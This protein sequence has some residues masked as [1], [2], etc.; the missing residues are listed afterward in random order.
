MLSVSTTLSYAQGTLKKG[1][2][3][4]V[5]NACLYPTSFTN[6]VIPGDTSFVAS[7]VTVVSDK[8]R[9]GFVTG[10]TR[11]STSPSQEAGQPFL[12][13]IYT[14]GESTYRMVFNDKVSSF[15]Q[16]ET[17]K[18]LLDSLGYEAF[19]ANTKEMDRLYDRD[20]KEDQIVNLLSKKYNTP[21]IVVLRDNKIDQRVDSN[22]EGSGR[23]KNATGVMAMS[24]YNKWEL[25]NRLNNE[26]K[27]VDEVAVKEEVNVEWN[28]VEKS[29]QSELPVPSD[30]ML[31]VNAK[32][33]KS[34]VN[35]LVGN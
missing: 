25:Y 18:M 27:K 28:K 10:I 13:Y 17:V 9:E 1:A 23:S 31:F 30:V 2:R 22:C 32:A 15:I 4:C 8:G 5:I 19:T 29:N 12:D 20:Y 33:A 21:T 3:I 6:M 26:I 14:S 35:M 34:F 24:S 16:T 11:K 7:S